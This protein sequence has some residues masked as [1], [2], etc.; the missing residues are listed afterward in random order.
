MRNLSSPLV[1]HSDHVAAGKIISNNIKSF[2][3]RRFLTQ[4]ISF[5]LVMDVDFAP[6]GREFV[7]GGYDKTIRIF[8]SHNSKSRYYTTI[9]LFHI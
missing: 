9:I 4:F 1:L 5:R 7:S 2:K 8:P 6:T 3:F